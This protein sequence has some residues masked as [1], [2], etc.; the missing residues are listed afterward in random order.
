[1]KKKQINK[2]KDKETQKGENEFVHKYLNM[3]VTTEGKDQE[4]IELI[5]D[6][7][8]QRIILRFSKRCA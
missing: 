1:V 3:S 4:Q 2:K 5:Q 8:Q 7:V 6:N